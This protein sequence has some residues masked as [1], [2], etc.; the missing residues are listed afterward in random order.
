MIIDS[1]AVAALT[2][3][4]PGWQELLSIILNAT[5]RNMSAASWLETAVVIDAR[6]DPVLSRRLD[7][8]LEALDVRICDVTPSQGM[9]ARRAYQDFG[10][11]RQGA[12]LTFGDC[13]TYALAADYREPLLCK[14][15]DFTHTD[16]DVVELPRQQS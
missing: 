15:D 16:V 12:G 7:E 5:S 4:E 1:S 3:E 2:F 13:F 8:L 14:G 6:N 9:L 11:G 10:K